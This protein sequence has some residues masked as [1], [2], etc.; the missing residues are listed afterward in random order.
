MPSQRS[1]TVVFHCHILKLV[2]IKVV[3]ASMALARAQFKLA[4]HVSAQLQLQ[5]C[6][7][8]L[9]EHSGDNHPSI[10]PALSLLGKSLQRTED[11][12]G[13]AEQFKHAL[14]CTTPPTCTAPCGSCG[15][16][17]VSNTRRTE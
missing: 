11:F 14:A 4:M 15:V 3:P 7:R 2:S 9:I 13:A 10:A 8:C 17:L 12:A 5:R 1:G 16:T 6:V